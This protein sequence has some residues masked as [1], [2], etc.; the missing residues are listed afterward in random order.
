MPTDEAIAALMTGEAPPRFTAAQ[1]SVQSQQS[2]QSS[3]V[4]FQ[5]PN[6]SGPTR[7]TAATRDQQV[8]IAPGTI[9]KLAPTSAHCEYSVASQSVNRQPE[10][11]AWLWSTMPMDSAWESGMCGA[12][13]LK[14]VNLCSARSSLGS[15]HQRMSL[16]RPSVMFQKTIP[17]TLRMALSGSSLQTCLRT[18]STSHQQSH[19]RQQS[20]QSIAFWTTPGCPDFPQY[21]IRN[22]KDGIVARLCL[23]IRNRGD[24]RG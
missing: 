1:P 15:S 9:Y 17:L 12:S 6:A 22:S 4:P 3:G 8:Q 23:E 16:L 19:L 24:F 7:T 21:A 10:M 11:H 2:S 13:V 20:V 14:L 5:Q 18:R